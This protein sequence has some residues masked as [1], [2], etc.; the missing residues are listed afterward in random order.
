MSADNK[1]TD[2]L[3]NPSGVITHKEPFSHSDNQNKDVKPLS[4]SKCHLTFSKSD[5]LNRHLSRPPVWCKPTTVIKILKGSEEAKPE[6][7][8]QMLSETLHQE[9]K[10]IANV[11]ERAFLCL[12]C[13]VEFLQASDLKSHEQSHLN[14]RPFTCSTCDKTFKDNK[15]LRRHQ[16]VHT[17]EKPFRCTNCDTRFT[18]SDVLKRHKL[19]RC[20]GKDIK[21]SEKFKPETTVEMFSDNSDV[22]KSHPTLHQEEG[23]LPNAKTRAF[24]CLQF[25]VEFRQASDLKR[26]EQSHLN[27]RPFACSKFGKNFNRFDH[28]RRQRCDPYHRSR[29]PCS[30][31]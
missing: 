2:N 11:K 30:H 17:G 29:G 7:T 4:C 22:L 31:T 27:I 25:N 21:E 9:G 15:H 6:E 19:Y 20:K 10:A 14:L 18:R 26:H 13:N 24:S 3:R 28:L 1:S 16:T 12:Q 8:V 5:S 23:A